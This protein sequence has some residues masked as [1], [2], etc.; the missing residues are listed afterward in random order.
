MNIILKKAQSSDLSRIHAIQISAFS[1]LLRKYRDYDTNP[2]AENVDA[3]VH[4]FDLSVTT[5]YF[6]CLD[7]QEIGMLRVCDHGSRCRISPICILPEFQGQGVGRQA[8]LLAE[9]AHSD[10]SCWELDTILQ[11]NSL[12]A[13]YESIGY[14]DTGKRKHLQDGMDLIFYEKPM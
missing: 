6:I 11:E 2:G 3:I 14:R 7:G 1:G 9:K 13:F 5:Y 8:I 10:A 12:C 4:R